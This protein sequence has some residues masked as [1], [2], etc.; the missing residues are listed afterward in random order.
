MKGAC[1]CTSVIVSAQAAR[2]HLG[3]VMLP[4]HLATHPTFGAGLIRV[5]P[6]WEG[7]PAYVFAVTA[8]R[9]LPAKTQELIR[10]AKTEFAKRVAQLESVVD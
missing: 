1:A 4:Q 6:D 9:A 8:D 3:I 5:L 7:T 2:G 10:I